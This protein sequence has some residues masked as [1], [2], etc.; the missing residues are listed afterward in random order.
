MNASTEKTPY[1]TLDFSQEFGKF[2]F[3][4]NEEAQ[5]WVTKE[6]T[7]WGW[8]QRHNWN[9]CRNAWSHFGGNLS[10][11]LS[12]LRNAASQEKKN[13]TS[14]NFVNEAK[15][16]IER[17]YAN[18]ARNLLPRNAT[19][20]F[21]FNLKESGQEPEAALIVAL[22]LG[23]DLRDAPLNLAVSALL[24]YHFFKNGIKNRTKGESDALKKLSTEF[25]E[26]L[27]SQ[28]LNHEA[29]KDTFESLRVAIE[30]YTEK[31][32]TE[33]EKSQSVRAD[34]WTKELEEARNDLTAL[35]E[36]YDNHMKL[37]APVSYWD[38]KRVKH[39][40]WSFGFFGLI[41]V[42]MW[43]FG[44]LL[45]TELESVSKAVELAKVMP[46]VQNSSS[47][48]VGSMIELASTWKIGSF[49]LLATLGFW[50]IRILVRLFLSHIHLE[51][52]AA[53]RVTMAQTFLAL[54]RDSALSGT[55]HIGTILAALFRPTG[56]GIVKDEGLPPTAM[57]WL[58]K[59]GGNK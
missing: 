16:F 13:Q 57:E 23:Q 9:P 6:Q 41:C 42:A 48:T 33:F 50:V 36:T 5:Q 52:D 24:L 40:N 25:K 14:Q 45:V 28:T 11:A 18:N 31:I 55:E 29:N 15:T 35:T 59:L 53:E 38:K 51:N 12:S 2:I 4:N 46:P 34:E 27:S 7:E 39:R 3:W 26:T 56:D 22:I 19:R 20:E 8:V 58:T 32:Q 21:L 30:S 1:L 37:A 10:S 47:S 49:I 17:A 43:R 54:K 44:S